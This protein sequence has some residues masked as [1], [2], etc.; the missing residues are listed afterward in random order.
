MCAESQTLS[1]Y[2]RV[3]HLAKAFY[4]DRWKS[5]YMAMFTAYFDASGHPDDPNVRSL[6][7][8]G[9]LASTDQWSIFD[10]RWK[11]ILEKYE[12]PYLHMKEFSHSQGEFVGW[13]QDPKK[14]QRPKFI[15]ELVTLLQKMMRRSFAQTISLDDY[16]ENEKQYKI[17]KIASPLAI[18]GLRAVRDLV[19]ATK[20]MHQPLNELLVFFEDGD[21]DKRNLDDWVNGVLGIKLHFECKGKIKAFEACDLLAYEHLQAVRKMIPEPGVYALEDLRK[22]FQRLQSIPHVLDGVDHWGIVMN[23]SLEESTKKMLAFER[24]PKIS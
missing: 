13:D 18:T 3:E 20:A 12:V 22:S 7:V 24:R 10:R 4:F 16:R 5:A 11:K 9:F 2:S 23:P 8:A 14:Q 1:F 17:R 21:I 6:T 19:A 15:G